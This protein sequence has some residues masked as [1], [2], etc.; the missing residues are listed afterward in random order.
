M[1][2]ETRSL[3]D[4]PA[5]IILEILLYLGP[6]DLTFNI[7]KLG[8]RWG[9]LAKNKTLWKKLTYKCDRSTDLDRISEVR[10]TTFLG[11]RTN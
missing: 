9:A 4:F 6:E 7:P 1:A 8:D 2:S 10:C 3:N 11:F 5:E